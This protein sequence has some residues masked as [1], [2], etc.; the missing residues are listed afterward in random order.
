MRDD[1]LRGISDS[2][3]FEETIELEVIDQDEATSGALINQIACDQEP[4]GD[5]DPPVRPDTEDR[6]RQNPFLLESLYFRSF[7]GTALLTKKEELART[8]RLRP[9]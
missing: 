1:G 7:R 2:S 9:E 8:L 5:S 6:S 4:D 3:H